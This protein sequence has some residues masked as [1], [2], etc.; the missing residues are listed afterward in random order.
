M[1][2]EIKT[3]DLGQPLGVLFDTI[4][5]YK[6]EDLEKFISELNHDQALYCIIQACQSAFKRNSYNIIESE[7]LS[8]AIRK[9]STPNIS[10]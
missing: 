3:E 4:N 7:L 8:K 5:Y 9:I 10:S 1:E 2:Q 6:L